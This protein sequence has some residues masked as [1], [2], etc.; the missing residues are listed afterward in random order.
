MKQ[1]TQA[2]L[3]GE[4][5]FNFSAFFSFFFFSAVLYVSLSR[6]FHKA[7]LSQSRGHRLASLAVSQSRHPL[8]CDANA[9]NSGLK[10]TAHRRK[11]IAE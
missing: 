1:T 8:Y 6:F 4:W 7:A 11:A 9:L 3:G 10:Q 2:T 5:P